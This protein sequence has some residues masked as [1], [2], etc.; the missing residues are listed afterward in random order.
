MNVSLNL[1][2]L[3]RLDLFIIGHVYA[4]YVLILTVAYNLFPVATFSNTNSCTIR[5]SVVY[6][7]NILITAKDKGY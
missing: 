4:I 1:C 7:H 2:V 5:N 6:P 3:C